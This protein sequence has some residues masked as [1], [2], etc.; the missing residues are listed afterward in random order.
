MPIVDHQNIDFFATILVT[1]LSKKAQNVLRK[2][3]QRSQKQQ[4]EIG[5][6]LDKF[7]RVQKTIKG[8]KHCVQVLPHHKYDIMFHTHYTH[9]FMDIVTNE[10]NKNIPPSFGDI[11][12]HLDSHCVK[13]AEYICTE[14][15]YFFIDINRYFEISEAEGY[16][17]AVMYF[18]VIF[19]W[20]MF[21]KH[22][23]SALELADRYCQ[24]AGRFDNEFVQSV[25]D[26][27]DIVE[28][29]L[30]IGGSIGLERVSPYI[31]KI[32]YFDGFKTMDITFHPWA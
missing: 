25:I 8:E 6:Y 18:T 14:T 28:Y 10:R 16:K 3:L 30:W 12:I 27:T 22:N 4:I 21:G 1:M 2:I 19:A 24:L 15:G 26:D 9:S 5:G 29:C 20:Y 17:I 13:H 7:G 32:K 23:L 31:E 11:I